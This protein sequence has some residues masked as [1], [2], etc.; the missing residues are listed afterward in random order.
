MML[1]P[2]RDA[3]KVADSVAGWGLVSG[4]GVVELTEGGTE[5]GDKV[6][7]IIVVAATDVSV[8]DVG[9]MVVGVEVFGTAVVETGVVGSTTTIFFMMLR[10][11]ALSI[12]D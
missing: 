12:V 1:I 9:A 4:R 10:I 6:V 2:V 8:T 11:F 5:V 3:L 7:I